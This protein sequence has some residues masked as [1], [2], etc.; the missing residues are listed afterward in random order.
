MRFTKLLIVLAAS[1]FSGLAG[2]GM[3]TNYATQVSPGY[4]FASL[5]SARYSSNTLEY[6]SCDLYSSGY[7]S[8]SARDA[9]GNSAWCYTDT[10]AQPTFAAMILAMNSASAVAF[11]FDTTTHACT[12]LFVRGGSNLLP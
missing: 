8:C 4:V 11:W 12:S 6:L 3:K 7:I 10:T 1:L 2:A 9:S 5:S